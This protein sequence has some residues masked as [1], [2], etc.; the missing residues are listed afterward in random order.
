[1]LRL[2]KSLQILILKNYFAGNRNSV[3]RILGADVTNRTIAGKVSGF[4]L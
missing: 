4:T 3:A 2:P 1:M